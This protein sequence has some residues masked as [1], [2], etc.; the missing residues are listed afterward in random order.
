MT[1]KIWGDRVKSVQSDLLGN[2]LYEPVDRNHIRCLKCD[3]TIPFTM[4]KTIVENERNK[5]SSMNFHL[6]CCCS[7]NNV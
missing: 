1:N 3:E 7:G 2:K 4:G 6:F 5:K